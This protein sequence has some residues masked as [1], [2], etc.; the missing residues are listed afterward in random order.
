MWLTGE[1]GLRPRSWHQ[2]LSA[3]PPFAGAVVGAQTVSGAC[4]RA[5]WG[6]SSGGGAA[7]VTD[8]RKG[9]KCEV[10]QKVSSA[11]ERA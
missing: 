4:G 7:P 5:Q 11:C 2:T 10:T 1:S 3:D 8:M 6:S 9:L